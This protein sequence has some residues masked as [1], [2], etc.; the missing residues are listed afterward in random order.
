MTNAM[1]RLPNRETPDGIPDQTVDA[2]LFSTELVWLQEVSTYLTTGLLPL[3]MSLEDKKW[4]VLRSLPFT[5]VNGQLYRLGMDYVLR[6]CIQP[7][8][9]E[10]FFA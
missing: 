4:L 2:K 8:K 7:Y 5:M 6:K 1:S 9:V 3:T 10:I